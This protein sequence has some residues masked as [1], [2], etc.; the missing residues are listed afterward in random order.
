MQHAWEGQS[1]VIS[2]NRRDHS[3]DLSIH[4]RIILKCVSNKWGVDWIRLAQDRIHCGAFMNI[5]VSRKGENCL[6]SWVTRIISQRTLL[7]LMCSFRRWCPR[8]NDRP[9]EYGVRRGTPGRSTSSPAASPASKIIIL[10][11][12]II[13]VHD[14]QPES[15]LVTSGVCG[16]KS[17]RPV[18]TS[19]RGGCR[20]APPTGH[21]MAQV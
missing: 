7:T 18:C 12:C 17:L 6:N 13:Y 15:W 16:G 5:H 8:W 9:R 19:S 10:V 14:V 3:E 4:G 2:L 1:S 21:K 11:T 20:I